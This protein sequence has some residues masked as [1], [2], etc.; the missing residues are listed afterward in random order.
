MDSEDARR[1]SLAEQHERRREVIRA[2]KR[3]VSRRRIA[4]EV[5]LGYSATCKIIG[6]K[7]SRS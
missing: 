1:L 6:P 4:R 2:Y 3:K 7:P 5:G